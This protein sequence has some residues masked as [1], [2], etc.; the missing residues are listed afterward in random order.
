MQVTLITKTMFFPLADCTYSEFIQCKRKIYKGKDGQEALMK[1]V[2]SQYFYKK[3][4]I[5][6][7]AQDSIIGEL[8]NGDFTK[9]ETWIYLKRIRSF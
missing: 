6:I 3:C 7:N 4:K 1:K 8:I 9:R 5:H 2:L